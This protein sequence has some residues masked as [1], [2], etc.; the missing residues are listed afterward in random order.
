MKKSNKDK[1][2]SLVLLGLAV[3]YAVFP[4]DAVPDVVPVLG[5]VDDA[6]ILISA[7]LNTLE[8]TFANGSA[9]LEK[10][11]K[12]AKY[13]TIG[14]GIVFILLIVLLGIVVY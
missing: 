7:S 12:F 6:F 2:L 3:A 4:I 1:N 8:K 5:W 13:L 11:L 9:S 14:L 10:I